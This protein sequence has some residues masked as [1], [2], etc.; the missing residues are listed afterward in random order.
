MPP[1]ETYSG[2]E[3]NTVLTTVEGMT[4]DGDVQL[5]ILAH[6][7]VIACK[8]THVDRETALAEIGKLW[9]RDD[10]LVPLRQT[11]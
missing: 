2:T 5:S 10:P 6:A 7:L 11:N 9:D 8:S 3:I 1:L 4:G